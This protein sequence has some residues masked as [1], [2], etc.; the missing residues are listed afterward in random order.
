MASQ[1]AAAWQ[2]P[3]SCVFAPP[4][5]GPGAF[6]LVPPRRGTFPPRSRWFLRST[7]PAIIVGSMDALALQGT[8]AL[9][10]VATAAFFLYLL[11]LKDSRSRSSEYFLLGAFLLHTCVLGFHFYDVG[12]PAVTRT[13]DALLFYGWLMVGVYLLVQLKYP[14]R[15]LG[16]FVAPLAFL[17]ALGSLAL[18]DEA[19]ELP[20]AL[21]T[22]WLPIHVTLA[23]LGNAV[24]ALAFGVSV[25]YLLLQ[26]QLKNKRMMALGKGMPALETLDRLNTVF[27]LWGF[28]LMTLG[29]ITGSLWARIQWG[30][31]WSWDPRQITSAMTWLLYGLLLHG[32]MTAGWRGRKAAVWTIVGF[33]VVLGYFLWGDLLFP[34]RHGGR[35]E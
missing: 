23:L 29:I 16:C 28:P 33:T 34:S 2:V 11:S 18:G 26:W 14:L 4:S 7:L 6:R 9:Y 1:G 30:S 12:Y 22:Y 24:F 31:Y 17:M 25:T 32:R 15:V 5:A 19:Q 35:F 20:P 21:M 10:L 3:S 8:A 13:R 27:L